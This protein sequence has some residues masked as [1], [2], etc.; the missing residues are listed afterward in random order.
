MV[1]IHKLVGLR[2]VK[3]N[4]EFSN[5]L[6]PGGAKRNCRGWE[7]LCLERVSGPFSGCRQKFMS[8]VI[9]NKYVHMAFVMT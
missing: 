5:L 6:L 1:K 3:Y 4:V 2:D 8:V 9:F 7:S